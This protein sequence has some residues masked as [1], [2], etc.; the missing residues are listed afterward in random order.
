M[1]PIAGAKGNIA[2]LFDFRKDVGHCG[3]SSGFEEGFVGCTADGRGGRS[4]SEEIDDLGES[5]CDWDEVGAA[6]I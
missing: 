4:R 3:W 6:V 1:L 2:A 5:D